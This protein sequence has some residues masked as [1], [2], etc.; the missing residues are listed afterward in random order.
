MKLFFLAVVLM[1]GLF[2]TNAVDAANKLGVEKAYDQAVAKARKEDKMLVMVVVKE[3][4]RWCDKIVNRTLSDPTVRKMLEKSVTVIVDKDA[5]FP[6]EFKVDFF[7]SVFYIDAQS[8]KSV[9][10]NVGYVDAEHFLNDIHDAQRIKGLQSQ[11]K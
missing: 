4:C 2:A 5:P 6:S 7:P 1:T 10:E 8:G 9:Y 3:N 11:K